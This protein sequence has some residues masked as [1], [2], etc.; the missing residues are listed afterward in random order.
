MISLGGVPV[1]I[2]TMITASVAMGIAV[3]GTVHLLTWFRDGILAGH[4]RH[5]A[6]AR[7]LAHCGPALWQTSATIALAMLMAIFTDLLLVS[8]FGWIMS[9]AVTAALLADIALTPALLAGP[10]GGLIERGF[11]VLFL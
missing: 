10:L 3:D 1:D 11:L 7:A 8:R 2:G 6:V 4:D 5:E 9:A